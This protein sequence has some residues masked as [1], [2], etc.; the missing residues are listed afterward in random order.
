MGS[1]GREQEAENKKQKAGRTQ[2][3]DGGMT[4]KVEGRKQK[5]DG[6]RRQ[7]A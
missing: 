2:T 1:E 5:G 3:A 4:Q 7:K 6:R